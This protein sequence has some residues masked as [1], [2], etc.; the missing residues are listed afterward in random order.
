MSGNTDL[1]E[2]TQALLAALI[3]STVL[4]VNDLAVTTTAQP[5]SAT[6]ICRE[7]VVMNDKN[8]ATDVLIG[9]ATT[10]TFPLAPGVAIPIP[11]TNLALLY[12][13]VATGTATLHFFAR[14]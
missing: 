4:Y 5:I 6:Q 2:V 12:A 8:S 14:N 3:P 9:N 11:C 1:L 10:Q 13:K 7:L